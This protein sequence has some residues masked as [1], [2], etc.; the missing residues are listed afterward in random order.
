MAVTRRV[1][2]REGAM[3]VNR[4]V[5]S[6]CLLLGSGSALAQKVNTD[7]DRSVDFSQYKTYAWLE[8]KN[9]APELW[10]PLRKG[11]T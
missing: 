6:V 10:T 5:L 3:R 1:A 2:R 9:P 4:I 7:Y 11:R 8:S